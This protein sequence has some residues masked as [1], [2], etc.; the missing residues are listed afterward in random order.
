MVG[1][2]MILSKAGSSMIETEEST[3]DA[4]GRDGFEWSIFFDRTEILLVSLDGR[5]IDRRL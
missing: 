3:E 1:T 5:L 2:W 4:L